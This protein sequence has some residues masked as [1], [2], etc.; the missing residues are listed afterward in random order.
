MKYLIDIAIEKIDT[1]IDLNERFCAYNLFKRTN[2]RVFFDC[3]GMFYLLDI[4][5]C[6]TV[7]PILSVK[8]K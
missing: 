7:F 4:L 1:L 6:P 2:G 5:F 3:R 8:A